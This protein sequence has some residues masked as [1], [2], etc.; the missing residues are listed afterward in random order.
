MYNVVHKEETHLSIALNFAALLRTAQNQGLALND[1]LILL[2]Q[3]MQKRFVSF[4]IERLLLRSLNFFR[5]SHKEI[6]MRSCCI[7]DGV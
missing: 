6:K 2:K 5:K 4:E 1:M 3:L 7:R